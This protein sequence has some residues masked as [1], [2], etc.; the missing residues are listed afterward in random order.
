MKKVFFRC[1][2]PYFTHLVPF[3][4]IKANIQSKILNGEDNEMPTGSRCGTPGGR[5]DGTFWGRPRD[6]DHT[7]FLNSTQKHIKLTLTG[8]SRLYNEL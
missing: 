6:V 5:N 3:F 8:Y 7:C 4:T 1:N 2:S